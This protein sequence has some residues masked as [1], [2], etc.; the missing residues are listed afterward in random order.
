MQ[1]NADTILDAMHLLWAEG[2][3][4]LCAKHGGGKFQVV[5]YFDDYEQL[6]ERATMLPEGSDAWW[7][8]HGMDSPPK[9]GRGSVDDISHVIAMS[10]DFDWADAA[11][12]K[13]TMLPSES[14]VRKIVE[15]MV[16]QPTVVVN[17]GHGLQVYWVLDRQLDGTEGRRLIDGFF[18]YVE[19]AYDLRNDRTDLASILRVPGSTNNKAEPV[20]VTVER[21]DMEC[22]VVDWVFENCWV[23]E[24]E[25]VRSVPLVP[26]VLPVSSLV[27]DVRPNGERPSD[28]CNRTATVDDVAGWLQQ[29]G[30]AFEKMERGNQ[31]WM[32]P[33]ISDHHGLSLHS[34]GSCTVFTSNAP[35]EFERMGKPGKGGFTLLT[36]F[37]VFS[38]VIH[39]GDF[40][41]AARD[42]G[43]S[44]MPA[45]GPGVQ[46]PGP[47]QSPG[48]KAPDED[49][50]TR[51][52]AR[53]MDML[54]STDQ[55][56]QI[57][58][59][60]PLIHGWLFR[61]SLAWMFG[62][63]GSGK[64]FAAVD[65]AMHVGAGKEWHGHP[66]QQ[67]KVLYMAAEG[68]AGM[69][70]RTQAWY[71]ANGKRPNDVY[72]LRE[73]VNMY[74]PTASQEL[75]DAG[76]IGQFDLI[77]IDTLARA[78]VGAEEN[79]ARDAGILIDNMDQL[80]VAAGGACVL[81][82]H[83]TGKDATLGGRGSSAFRGAM[84]SEI[85]VSGGLTN[86]T[87]K[88][89]K[90]KN[91]EQSPNLQFFGE[92][93]LISGSIALRRLMSTEPERSDGEVNDVEFYRC[94]WDIYDGTNAVTA[95]AWAAAVKEAHGLSKSTF[96]RRKKK[97]LEHPHH[98]TW[99]RADRRGKF[100]PLESF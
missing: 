70:S 61:D 60:D 96:D 77:I 78:S 100:I 8:V 11:A 65:M 71:E 44:Q 91:I 33:G 63:S 82:I 9:L 72:W 64:S 43:Q 75:I 58:P 3:H 21:I 55:L 2:S 20:E 23:P 52:G 69:A 49:E 26:S 73:A 30:W 59:P 18:R 4:S 56:D 17:S 1:V 51:P 45:E 10:A 37:D 41:A 62:P 40:S 93:Q 85:E 53:I 25:P 89:T 79:S 83:H 38:A 28:H 6:L 32:R 22:V 74:E 16:P 31:H 57:T 48:S 66:V 94:L 99:I 27:R 15:V 29:A 98:S 92:H 88:N 35:V 7:G 5:G 95:A 76:R 68:V 86:L 34:N 80:R 47:S 13:G 84:E 97:L 50:P 14:Q 24:P 42:W 46:A 54:L 36:P 19:A 87:L 39:R 12:H 67:G 90:Q 81:V